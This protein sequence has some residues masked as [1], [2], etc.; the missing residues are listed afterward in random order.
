MNKII[1]IISEHVSLPKCIN[2]LTLILSGIIK[3]RPK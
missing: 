2:K 1:T 3:I